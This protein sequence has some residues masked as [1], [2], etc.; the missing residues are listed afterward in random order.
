MNDFS[1]YSLSWI[2]KC[3]SPLI[4][5]LPSPPSCLTEAA[6]S[7]T[8]NKFSSVRV[9]LYSRMVV[10]KKW[11]PN[12]KTC[13]KHRFLVP[14]PDLPKQKLWEWGL[15]VCV[16]TCS[17]GGSQ[18]SEVLELPFRA[19]PFCP[20][21][22]PLKSHPILWRYLLPLPFCDAIFSLRYYRHYFYI[23]C[24]DNMAAWLWDFNQVL[25]RT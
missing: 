4:P 14:T 6:F 12:L 21:L 7:P 19:L 18:H 25:L 13:E 23:H 2:Q 3:N 16:L 9:S 17:P 20:C 15:A 5:L 1:T 22:F 24:Y 10:L 11:S 8:S